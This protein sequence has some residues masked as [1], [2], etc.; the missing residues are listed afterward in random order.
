MT[1]TYGVQHSRFR[2]CAPTN[3]PT[4]QPTG[5]ITAVAGQSWRYT[6]PHSAAAHAGA[7]QNAR[8]PSPLPM[9]VDTSRVGSHLWVHSGMVG[10]PTSR[11]G[12]L[13]RRRPGTIAGRLVT[14]WALPCTSTTLAVGHPILCT[15][16]YVHAA[17]VSQAAVCLLLVDHSPTTSRLLV[18]SPPPAYHKALGCRPAPA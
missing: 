15:C 11:G 17:D 2:G 1:P 10:A 14:A 18:T 7:V 3:Q 12:H 6:H 8:R 9:A 4:N 16:M 13:Q 5:C